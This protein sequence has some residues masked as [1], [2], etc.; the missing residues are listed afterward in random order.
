MAG[1]IRE[2]G[3]DRAE[4]L[5]LLPA[6]LGHDHYTV[7]GETIRVEHPAGAVEI[8]LHPTRTRRI[9]LLAIPATRVE[10]RFGR[11]SEAERGALL[12][13]FDRYYQKGGG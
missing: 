6:A 7:E 8:R 13:R 3:L 4:F 1:C 5:R 2:M 9:A 11:L 12:E 10:F